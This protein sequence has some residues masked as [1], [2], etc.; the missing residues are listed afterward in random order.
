MEAVADAQVPGFTV[1]SQPHLTFSQQSFRVEG[2]RVRLDDLAWRPAPLDHLVGASLQKTPAVTLERLSGKPIKQ[3]ISK[4][5]SPSDSEHSRRV[6]YIRR[7]LLDDVGVDLLRLDLL[8]HG[9]LLPAAV[10]GQKR[11][12]LSPR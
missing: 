12:G 2:M 4:T 3:T 10:V 9:D 1:A 6:L 5:H 7:D 8:R 11:N